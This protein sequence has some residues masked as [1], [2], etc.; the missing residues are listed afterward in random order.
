MWA[1]NLVYRCKKCNGRIDAKTW[2]WF[3]EKRL[4]RGLKPKA[5]A[6]CGYCLVDAFNEL[7]DEV[8]K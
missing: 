8:D 7:M 4:E 3:L 1:E 2:L 5:P 6:I